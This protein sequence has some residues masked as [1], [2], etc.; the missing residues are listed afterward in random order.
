MTC[1]DV[2][3]RVTAY[4][5]GDLDA[6]V[7]SAVRGHLRT[8]AACRD[9]AQAE[10]ALR[11][12]L[13]AL[14]PPPPPAQ[15]WSQ[16][17]ARLAEAEVADSRRGAAAR[18]WTRLVAWRLPLSLAAVSAAAMTLLWLRRAELPE[19][20]P[21][22]QAT[23]LAPPVAGAPVRDVLDELAD[24]PA[25]IDAQFAGAVEELVALAESDR[26]RWPAPRAAAFS[27]ELAARRAAIA[28]AAV[29]RPREAAWRGLVGYLQE[30]LLA[31]PEAP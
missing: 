15:L 19:G 3:A 24:A 1:R 8:C 6:A 11:T 29:G 25:V 20:A 7:T 13:A 5:D 17:Q 30:A 23:A 27:S 4:V 28:S 21:G 26:A 9:E 22:R 18:I 2:A 12:H 10:A 31:D 14:P 16:I